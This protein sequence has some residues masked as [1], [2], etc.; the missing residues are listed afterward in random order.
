MNV[1]RDIYNSSPCSFQSMGICVDSSQIL[2]FPIFLCTG[3]D[4]EKLAELCI[5]EY[6]G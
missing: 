1:L 4:Q 2:V 5:S 6:V 3:V